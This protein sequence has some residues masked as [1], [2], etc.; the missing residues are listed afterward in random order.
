MADEIDRADPP[1]PITVSEE[2]YEADREK[3]MDLAT[4]DGQVIV[5]DAEGATILILGRG[6]IPPST[7]PMEEGWDEAPPGHDPEKPGSMDW[8]R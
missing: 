5:K 7:V 6:Y 3:Y 4:G 1:T 8:F 2:T